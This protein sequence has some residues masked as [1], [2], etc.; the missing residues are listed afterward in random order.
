MFCQVLAAA[1]ASMSGFQKVPRPKSLLTQEEGLVSLRIQAKSGRLETTGHVMR[2][3]GDLAGEDATKRVC[4]CRSWACL[5]PMNFC[6]SP[7]KF[8]FVK[9]HNQPHC[10][11]SVVLP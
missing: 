5:H 11:I 2:V 6:A 1:L 7:Y 9:T 8:F 4:C 10:K 3:V